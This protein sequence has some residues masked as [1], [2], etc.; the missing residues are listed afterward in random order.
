VLFI[1]EESERGASVLQAAVERPIL[2][3][4]E[5]DRFLEEG[6]IIALK[7]IDRRV[8]FEI[9]AANAQRS[10]LRISSQLLGLALAVHEESQ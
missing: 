1:G 5:S 9:H 2:T 4:G 8:R 6:G 10:G 3:V 7:V